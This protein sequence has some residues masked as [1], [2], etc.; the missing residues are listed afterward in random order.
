[1]YLEY[2]HVKMQTLLTILTLIQP[3]CYMETI[4]LK[5]AYYSVKIDGG[6]ICFYF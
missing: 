1:M 2:K 4:E 3:N 5:V 6:K